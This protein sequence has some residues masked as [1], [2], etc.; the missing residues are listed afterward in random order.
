M[1]AHVA[2]A[3]KGNRAAFIR[4]DDEGGFVIS[5]RAGSHAAHVP[6][7]GALVTV[8]LQQPRIEPH[9]RCGGHHVVRDTHV[10]VRGDDRRAHL[11]VQLAP[12]RRPQPSHNPVQRPAN[13]HSSVLSLETVFA[14]AIHV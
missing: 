9:R 7:G 5:S 8:T 14:R 11:R 4:L 12:D 10:D 1:D 2:G 3:L 6:Q 13:R